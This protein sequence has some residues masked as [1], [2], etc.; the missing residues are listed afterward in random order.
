[1]KFPIKTRDIH[2]IGNMSSIGISV[3]S[4]EYKEKYTICVLKKCC[5][6]NYVDLLLIRQK[7]N[8]HY[9][10]LKYF[11]IFMYNYTLH[12]GTKHFSRYCLQGFRTA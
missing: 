11:N 5:E 7:S 12:R 4:Y 2:K 1:M 9:F 6:E 10:L 8:T 3:F